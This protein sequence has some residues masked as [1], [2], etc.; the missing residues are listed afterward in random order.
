MS[1][2]YLIGRSGIHGNKELPIEP[3]I[4][5]GRDASVCQLVY[6]N[7]EGR[8]SSVHCKIQ[9]F[10]GMVQLT[11]LGSTNGTFL[12][13]GVRLNPHTTQTLQSGQGFYIAD[14]SNSFVVRV[15]QDYVYTPDNGGS[16][17]SYDGTSGTMGFSIA[18]MVLGI[19]GILLSATFFLALILG[20]VGIVFG[21]YAIGTRKRG[22]KMAIAG[23]VCSIIAVA[24]PIILVVAGLA[25]ISG[26]LGGLL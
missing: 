21:A 10:N 19:V 2:A 11:D 20:I 26:I 7:Q 5:I 3:E 16:A 23:L 22:R 6:P 8:V 24:L 13:S 1:R 14:R 9:S 4:I 15:Q 17:G 25:A 18:S 12:D